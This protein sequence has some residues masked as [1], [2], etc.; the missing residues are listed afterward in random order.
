[1]IDDMYAVM[2][3]ITEIKKRFGLIKR[4]HAPAQPDEF[5]RR[6]LQAAEE[7]K[8]KAA[9]EEKP[10][11]GSRAMS[12]PEMREIARMAAVRNGVPPGLVDAVIRAES[13]YNPKAVSAKGAKGLMQLM[14][15][16]AG[17]LG[18]NDPFSPK[19][20][21]D[22]GVGLLKSLLDK[23]GGDY[24][25]ALAAYNAGEG[26]VDRNGGV[27]PYDETREYVKRVIELYLRNSE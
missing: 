18:V 4:T 27:P 1:M 17:T 9:A 2:G 13:S 23:Y 8:A 12:V 15:E 11:A 14:P 20:N 6:T 10:A 7:K 19:E 25:K 21:I 16:T 5:Q 22:A 26:A 3:R 24:K